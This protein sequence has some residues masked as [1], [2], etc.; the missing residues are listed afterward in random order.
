MMGEVDLPCA[1]YRDRTGF[2]RSPKPTTS[3]IF[4]PQLIQKNYIQLRE[5]SN[6][7]GAGSVE[8]DF[9]TRKIG[10]AKIIALAVI[11]GR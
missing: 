9:H 11:I 8:K 7:D 10:R 1:M 6:F 4:Y 2:D 3:P 5:N